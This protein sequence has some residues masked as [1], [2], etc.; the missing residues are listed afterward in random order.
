LLISEITSISISVLKCWTE[1]QKKWQC[2]WLYSDCTLLSCCYRL[3]QLSNYF[4]KLIT[5]L[6]TLLQELVSIY[7]SSTTLV[8][9]IC[10][11]SWAFQHSKHACLNKQMANLVSL[12][13]I[14]VKFIHTLS[15]LL[16]DYFFLFNQRHDIYTCIY[17]ILLWLSVHSLELYKQAAY[18]NWHMLVTFFRICAMILNCVC[19]LH[20]HLFWS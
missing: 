17:H 20:V 2:E 3:Y 16:S 8:Q 10:H 19:H 4:L 14:L 1:K 13:R 11:Y 5:L 6:E 18:W 9:I 7:F 12:F 15:Q